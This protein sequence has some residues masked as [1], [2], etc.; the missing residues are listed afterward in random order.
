MK[1]VRVRVLL[2]YLTVLSLVMLGC[3]KPDNFLYLHPGPSA[4]SFTKKL[5]DLSTTTS[6]NGGP[7]DIF[8]VIGGM[9]EQAAN[10]QSGVISFMT[11]FAAQPDWRMAVVSDNDWDPPFLGMPQIF[12][13]KDPNPVANF[14][15][16]VAGAVNAIDGEVLF[17]PTVAN[18]KAYPQFV[19]PQ[20]KL[21]II[22][23]ND[24]PDGSFRTTTAAQMTQFLAGLKGG[25]L[26]KVVVYGVIGATDLNCDPSTIDGDWNYHGTEMERLI[27]ATGGQVYSLCDASFG[28]SLAKI[29]N[30]ITSSTHYV[31]A[32]IP[33]D[34]KPVAAS[35]HVFYQNSEL[36]GGV[37]ANGGLWYYDSQRNAIIFYNLAFSNNLSGDVTVQFDEDNGAS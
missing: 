5:A 30:A 31:Q 27:N 24:A 13:N 16:G 6:T 4:V 34:K 3:N 15:N 19:R 25:D 17:D 22:L 28:T 8:W 23:T 9:T 26:S 21:V 2:R 12:D 18:L 7:L 14:T 10:F 36:A 35:I 32:W 1:T 20:A 11:N 33:L 37:Q 29:G